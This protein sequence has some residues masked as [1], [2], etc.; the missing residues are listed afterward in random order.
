MARRSFGDSRCWRKRQG[1]RGQERQGRLQ[2]DQDQPCRSDVR[3]ERFVAG[4]LSCEVA[5]NFSRAETLAFMEF[6]KTQT[7]TPETFPEQFLPLIGIL[8]QDKWVIAHLSLRSD[9]LIGFSR[10]VQSDY[11]GGPRQ[12]NPQDALS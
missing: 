12:R 5:V 9:W 1:R 4:G 11:Q 7:E 10:P 2:R 6:R 8:V 3:N